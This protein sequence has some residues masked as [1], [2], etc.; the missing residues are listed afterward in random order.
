MPPDMMYLCLCQKC[1]TESNLKETLDKSKRRDIR[2]NNWP[3]FFKIINVIN[4]KG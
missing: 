4:D 1:I 2:Q 3:V